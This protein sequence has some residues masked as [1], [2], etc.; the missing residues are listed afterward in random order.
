MF[1]TSVRKEIDFIT[2]LQ[3]KVGIKL[4]KEQ[5]ENYERTLEMKVLEGVGGFVPDLVKFG[6]LNKALGAAG[7]SAR[8]AQM[9]SSTNSRTKLKGHFLN[10]ILEE[11]KFKFITKGESQTGGGVGFYLG[12]L[13]MRKL[14]PFRFEGNMAA[15][16]PLLEKAILGGPGGASG[17]EVALMVEALYKEGMGSKS[18]EQSMIDD[19]G[20]QADAMGRIVV[21]NFVFGLVGVTRFKT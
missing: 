20:E 2:D 15:F 4:T 8:L 1:G 18:F 3:G 13:G 21:N 17:S 10:A 12:G 5:E 11:G 6:L 19:Y 16:N 14:V 7:I 9:I